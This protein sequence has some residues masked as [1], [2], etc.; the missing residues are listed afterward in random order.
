MDESQGQEPAAAAQ[1]ATAATTNATST[2][3]AQDGA[4]TAKQQ[5]TFD[6][7]YVGDLRNEA[8]SHRTRAKKAEDD[9]A[10]AQAKLKEYEDRDL[11]DQQRRDRDAA[12]TKAQLESLQAE[13]RAMVAE[14]REL[15]LRIAAL[16]IAGGL[17]IIDPEL[18]ML[19]MARDAITFDDAG[20][21]KR[22]TVEQALKALVEAKP[23]LVRQATTQATG[24]SVTNAQKG[25]GEKTAEQLAAESRAR[26]YGQPSSYFDPATAV[27]QG[28][29][30]FYT[31]ELPDAAG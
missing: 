16:S 1:D 21:P 23:Y 2:Q 9:L 7:K 14:R 18:A 11:T 22:E 5:E 4:T 24:G 25:S 27:K 28:G 31:P 12:D 10:A 13:Q 3:Q 20:Q 26:V 8:A 15:N 29:G 19:A 6:A 17:N 30:V